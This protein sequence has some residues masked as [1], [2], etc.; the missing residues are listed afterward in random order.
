[1]GRLS[2]H[3]SE[4]NA[5][6]TKLQMRLLQ[7]GQIAEA[8]HKGTSW[9][10]LSHGGFGQNDGLSVMG[11]MNVDLGVSING[12]PLSE[13]W[14][15][16]YQLVQA[17]PA[18]LERVE[19]LTG[20]D[21]VG[22]APSMTLT[23]LNMQ[24]MIHNSATPYTSLWYH[25]AGGDI[26]AMDGTFSQNVA[27]N[28]NVTLGVRRSGANGRYLNTD[29]DIWNIRAAIRWTMSARSH[30]HVHYELASLNSSLWGGIRTAG[31]SP[32]FTESTAPPVHSNLRDETRRHDLSATLTQI[33]SD[34]TSSVLSASV[35]GSYNALRRLRDSTTWTSV[36]DTL[37]ALTLRGGSVGGILRYDQRIG[38]LRLRIGGGADVI[39]NDA[40]VYADESY[41]VVP[42][43]FG[44]IMIPLSAGLQFR[45][46]G[47]VA[48]QF[49]RVLIGAG[50]GLSVQ[51]G[52][53]VYRADVATSQRAPTLSE[54]TSLLPERHLLLSVS[55]T[56]LSPNFETSVTAYGRLI[57]D[58]IVSTGSRTN[59]VM[60][61]TNSFNATSRRIIGAV[62]NSMLRIGN[63]ELR[64]RVRITISN[65]NDVADDRFP[66]AMADLSVAYVYEVGRN[67]VRL[68]V[69]G[70]V[71][72][73][74]RL[75]QYVAPSW[76]YV[77]PLTS[78]GGQ[79]DGLNVFLSAIVGNATV[80][81]SFEN[82]LGQR[83]YTTS[84]APEIVRSIRLSVDWSFFD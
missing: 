61:L 60:A 33:L 54:G 3:D 55:G 47:R 65:T 27:E 8:L 13:P 45:G 52:N 28:F 40:S 9:T 24:S 6:I 11:G 67:S 21:A 49:D 66:L 18:G 59:E 34:D 77:D 56:W 17:Q 10:P 35:Y 1:M 69:C 30:L 44:H 72:S 71:M 41:G 26:V 48:L 14:S 7:Y 23:A 82:I 68:G 19:L 36:T 29:F 50:A 57:T 81:A 31:L 78:T 15:G 64:P 12:R 53:A 80:R 63:V 79:Y 51:T 46:A 76:T 4:A 37:G 38:P 83:W 62:A 16:A 42:Q 25:Q 73:A 2:A 43:A 20:T 84:L 32:Q 74:A 75:P 22:L 5:H 39:R 70:T 58:P